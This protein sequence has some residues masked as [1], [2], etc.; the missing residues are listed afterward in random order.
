MLID[1]RFMEGRGQ[2]SVLWRDPYRKCHEWR[3]K[4]FLMMVIMLS[5][6]YY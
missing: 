5:V 4:V 1:K 6:L 2:A 3:W